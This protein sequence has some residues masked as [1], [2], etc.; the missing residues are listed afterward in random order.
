MA[1]EYYFIDFERVGMCILCAVGHRRAQSSANVILLS[2]VGEP[3]AKKIQLVIRKKVIP[4]ERD[5]NLDPSS[6]THYC[7]KSSAAV[8]K[9]LISYWEPHLFYTRSWNTYPQK[10]WIK[11]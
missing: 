7:I 8:Y 5:S 11:L 1:L 10:L 6:K 3:S 2:T 4:P 9:W